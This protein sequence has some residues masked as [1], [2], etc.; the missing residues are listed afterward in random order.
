MT[1]NHTLIF[2]VL[3]SIYIFEFTTRFSY[4]HICIDIGL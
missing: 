3:K 2:K 1:K 4:E